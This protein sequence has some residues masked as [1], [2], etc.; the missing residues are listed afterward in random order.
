MVD[1]LPLASRNTQHARL[2]KTYQNIKALC[3]RLTFNLLNV[4]PNIFLANDHK[5]KVAFP[6]PNAHSSPPL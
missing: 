3:P 4:C 2:K 1:R 5:A 6:L